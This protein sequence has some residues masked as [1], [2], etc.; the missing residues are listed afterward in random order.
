MTV[1]LRP[2]RWPEQENVW[3]ARAVSSNVVLTDCKFRAAIGG[4]CGLR[5][6]GVVS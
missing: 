2:Y 1:D 4:P 6:G 3:S 5:R